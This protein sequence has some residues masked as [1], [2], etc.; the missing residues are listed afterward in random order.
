MKTFWPRL[1]PSSLL[2]DEKMCRAALADIHQVSYL[3]AHTAL[4]D[5]VT[6]TEEISV[7]WLKEGDWLTAGTVLMHLGD[8]MLSLQ[9]IERARDYY[10]SAAL[11]FYVQVDS[12]HRQNEAAARYGLAIVDLLSNHQRNA[13][14]QLE[15]VLKL[16]KKAEHHWI[17]IQA[18]Y[19]NARLCR[20]AQS[21]IYD[22]QETA[23]ADLFSFPYPKLSFGYGHFERAAQRIYTLPPIR[24]ISL[25]RLGMEI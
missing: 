24:H 2:T 12:R 8:H 22:I 19:E 5:T 16:L 6:I 23:L 25:P 21:K 9:M 3:A 10:Q 17:S 4:D 15:K 13:I 14:H 20:Q 1:K 7:H 11:R 18:D